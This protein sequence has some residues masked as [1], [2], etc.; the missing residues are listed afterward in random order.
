VSRARLEEHRR[1]WA[2]KPSLARLYE[3][4]FRRLLA[5]PGPGARVAEVGA[6][7]GFLKARARAAAPTLRWTAIDLLPTPWNDLAADAT[8]LPFAAA[9][10]DAVL[11]LDVLHHVALP[12]DF[13]AEAGRTLRP[14]GTLALV[15]PWITP[16]SYPV[17]RFLH[18]ED[19]VLGID[20]RRPFAAGGLKDSFEGNA[21]VPWKLVGALAPADWAAVGFAPPRVTVL[22]TFPYLLSLGFRPRSLL[23]R[24]LEGPLLRLDELARP[25]APWLGLRAFLAWQRS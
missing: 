20:P 25:L 24:P 16:L 12:L 21:A 8:R 19:C 23:P 22:N 1:L 14:G 13:V 10:L 4:W 7:P 6:G 17:Y 18:Q 5:A 2:A 15:E 3:P 11:G 9:S